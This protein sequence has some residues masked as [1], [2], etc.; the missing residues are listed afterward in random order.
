MGDF[1]QICIFQ[2]KQILHFA[3]EKLL[4]MNTDLILHSRKYKQ[5]KHFERNKFNIVS[6]KRFDLESEAGFVAGEEKIGVHPVLL[7]SFQPFCPS[8][9]FS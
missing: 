2:N 6:P 5:K 1:E 7:N 4:K 3:T 9:C 8:T